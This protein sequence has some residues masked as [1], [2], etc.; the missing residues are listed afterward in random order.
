MQILTGC[1]TDSCPVAAFDQKQ[2]PA[3]SWPT[4]TPTPCLPALQRRSLSVI[5][6]WS[7]LLARK[8]HTLVPRYVITWHGV[9]TAA[10]CLASSESIYSSAACICSDKNTPT[11][12]LSRLFLFRPG[13]VHG[14]WQRTVILPPILCRIPGAA[15]LSKDLFVAILERAF[16][17]FSARQKQAALV[18]LSCKSKVRTPQAPVDAKLCHGRHLGA[19]AAANTIHLVLA[20]VRSEIPESLTTVR[21][22]ASLIDLQGV[23]SANGR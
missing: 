21:S 14:K 11:R 9:V 1:P 4:Q 23:C 10:K 18:I 13:L 6:W 16:P 12:P 17:V 3:P 19:M 8:N 2:S 7:C 20:I 5:V 22:C 15:N